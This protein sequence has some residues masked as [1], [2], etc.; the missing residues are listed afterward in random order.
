MPSKGN[1]HPGFKHCVI[2]YGPTCLLT[3]RSNP[4]F[5]ESHGLRG[6]YFPHHYCLLR[7]IALLLT[8][9]SNV[10]LRKGLTRL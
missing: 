1:N 10:A 6:A 4:S 5:S 7:I 2:G 9:S 8:N 3:D